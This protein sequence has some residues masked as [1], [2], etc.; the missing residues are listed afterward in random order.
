VPGA[1][2]ASPVMVIAFVGASAWLR[3]GGIEGYTITSS[4]DPAG[5]P[6][7]PAKVVACDALAWWGNYR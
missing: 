3:F 6:D 7:L 1:A 2:W 4:T 5:L